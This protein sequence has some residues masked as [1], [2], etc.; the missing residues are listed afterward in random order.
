MRYIKYFS[1]SLLVISI[2]QA[3]K[4]WVYFY[5]KMGNTG[6]IPVLGNW[7]KLHYILNPGMAFGITFD[8]IYG[9]LILTLFRI[10]ATIAIA[11]YIKYLVD[12]QAHKGFIFCM[13]MILGGASGN[14]IDSTFYGVYLDNAPPNAPTPWFYGQVIDM[15]YF[16]IWRGELPQW[17][18]LLG[19]MDVALF[20]IFNVAD[21]AIFIGVVSILVFQG[22]FFPKPK[23][24]TPAN[25]IEGSHQPAIQPM[26]QENSIQ[27]ASPN[28]ISPKDSQNIPLPND[29]LPTKN[30]RT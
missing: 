27:E 11:F 17:I 8:A 21:A 10:I 25:A 26:N 28:E 2:D 12:K 18:P 4:L 24:P 7:F 23:S 6:E 14:V 5:M 29:N 19:G 20:P 22:T 1:V 15:F 9:K 16:D 3:L 13:A 30:E